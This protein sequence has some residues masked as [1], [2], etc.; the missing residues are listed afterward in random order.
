MMERPRGTRDF[1]P[2]E[3]ARRRRVEGAMR[4]TALGF[5]YGEVQT[6]TFEH[7]DLFVARSGAA[8]VE[9]MYVFQDKGGR[10]LAL[11]PELTAAVMRMYASELTH[12]PKPLRLFYSGPCFRYE[13][14]QKGRYREFFQFGAEL[15]G[16]PHPEGDA[17]MIALAVRCI[18]SAG[19]AGTV[20][21]IGHVGA[22]R[23]LL[24]WM[25]VTGPLAARAFPL[26]DKGDLQGLEE[27]LMD[28]V[29][30]ERLEALADYVSTTGGPQVVARARAAFADAP[31]AV[32]HLARLD[33]ALEHLSHYPDI[34]FT[35]HLGI[36]RGLDYYTGVVFE[37]DCP[38]LG[39]EKQV[40]GG[41]AYE[42]GQVFGLKEV[43][44][45]GFAIGLDRVVLAAGEA[46]A[47]GGAPKEP[48]REGAVVVPMDRS[49]AVMTLAVR[50]AEA[51]R[52]AGLRAELEVLRRPVGKALKAADEQQLRWAVI[53]GTDEAAKGEVALKDLVSGEQRKVPLGELAGVLGR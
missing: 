6:P 50:A 30:H 26:I 2:E 10:S 32:A 7:T 14:P 34:L 27:L 1:L 21:R 11:R 9:E 31:A 18:G 35:V 28:H 22:L 25:G 24:E 41:G 3:M 33:E 42:L 36:A 49:G 51:V 29:P 23:A 52:A 47:A 48:I 38:G 44:A 43:P 40:C 53:V 15:I 37:V 12:A 46:A 4:R 5:G 8:V 20:V 17:E 16:S 13:R 39:A 19:L 45:T